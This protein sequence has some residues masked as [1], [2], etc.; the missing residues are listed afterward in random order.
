M[1]LPPLPEQDDPDGLVLE[2]PEVPEHRRQC[3]NHECRSPVGR[4]RAGRPG[5]TR[6][7]CS[8]CGTRFSFLPTLSRGELIGGRYEIVGPLAYGGV[9]WVYLAKDTVLDNHRVV[10]KGL[11]NP[12]DPHA[13]RAALAEKQYLIQLDH[14]NVVR[15][16]NFLTHPDRETGE[17]ADYIVMEF[18]SGRTLHELKRSGYPMPV[19]N[20][21]RYGL[22]I[23]YAFDYLHSKNLLYCDLK[24]DNVI[25]GQRVKLID[26]G[27]V[28][29]VDDTNSP[30][31]GHPDFQVPTEEIRTRG[32]T[33]R[34]DLYSV[35]RT[36]QALFATTQDDDHVHGRSPITF[37]VTSFRTVLDRATE[38]WAKRF[39]SAAEMADQLA[40]VLR[41]ITAL[42]GQPVRPEPSKRFTP[43][44][45]LLDEGLGTVPPVERW[46]S[47]PASDSV[48]RGKA[49]SDGRPSPASVAVTL[50]ESLPDP[51]DPATARLAAMSLTDPY[52]LLSELAPLPRSVETALGRCRAHLALRDFDAAR[53]D[54]DDARR[55]S[56]CAWRIDWHGALL[57]LAR[58]D[59]RSEPSAARASFQEVH[60]A[61]P[62]EIAPKLG[63]ALCAE[64]AGRR[65][66]AEQ[67]YHAI[68][69]TDGTLVSAA[70]GIA[71][72][73]LAD[74]HRGHSAEI[75]DEVPKV[76]RHYDAARVAAVL[77]RAGPFAGVDPPGAADLC[78]AARRLSDLAIDEAAWQRLTTVVRQAALDHVVR[79]QPSSTGDWDDA[80]RDVFG[81]PVTE[82]GL[83]AR[84]EESF[85]ELA[86][87]VAG[88]ANRHGTLIDLANTARP[89][90]RT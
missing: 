30:S 78:D 16:E 19:E 46:T 13:R 2:R 1:S 64:Y 10:L 27:A 43:L 52:R 67:L 18:V 49:L 34:S 50:P 3:G 11:I 20:V 88:D 77:V 48:V 62:G 28:R 53:R 22:H 55:I 5:L 54:L 58:S 76:S 87:Q 29:E 45:E 65:R 7:F 72:I 26:L 21:I 89:L 51:A 6:G 4:S 90:T 41:E 82:H 44:T 79:R 12:N 81:H 14:P 56:P 68:W 24:P 74:G 85:R 35:G 86:R 38:D 39:A 75:L 61:L 25:H 60:R 31:W 80:T 83:R 84:L 71:R 73:R 17:Q 40:G 8:F 32:L 37:G 66:D 69:C 47:V 9:G 42:R 70:F 59:G 15:I 36:L 23:L 57:A 33:V 63:L